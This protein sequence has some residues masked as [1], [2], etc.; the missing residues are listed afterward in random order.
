M[1]RYLILSVMFLT[2]LIGALYPADSVNN[3]VDV[4]GTVI[5]T[6]ITF[7][8]YF[9]VNSLITFTEDNS[10]LGTTLTD[11]GGNFHSNFGLASSGTHAFTITGQDAQNRTT[12]TISKIVDAQGDQGTV[13]NHLLLSPTIYASK[14]SNNPIIVI[15]G[16]ATPQSLITLFIQGKNIGQTLTDINGNWSNAINSS[17]LSIPGSYIANAS[18]SYQTYQSQISEDVSFTLDPFVPTPSISPLFSPTIISPQAIIKTSSTPLQQLQSTNV[19]TITHKIPYVIKIKNPEQVYSSPDTQ[20]PTIVY[21]TNAVPSTVLPTNSI[22]SPT[23]SNREKIVRETLGNN[24]QIYIFG[25]M[26]IILLPF[27][28]ILFG[29]IRFHK[30]EKTRELN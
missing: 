10:L 18:A 7:D 30:K 29:F 8:G 12:S 13:V 2:L 15:S 23:M 20:I 3:S 6:N 9:A 1:V 26:F 14:D 28:F 24:N 11:S 16:N 19:S 25:Y 17:I 21:P 27:L 22:V 5:A 4:S